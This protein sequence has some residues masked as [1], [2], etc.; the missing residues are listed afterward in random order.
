[1]A[2]KVLLHRGYLGLEARD[3]YVYPG[4]R[5]SA[6]AK[7]RD[8]DAPANLDRLAGAGPRGGLH[9]RAAALVELAPTLLVDVVAPDLESALQQMVRER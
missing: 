9:R 5:R 2:V 1:M 3:A 8:P 4:N 7:A 6:Q